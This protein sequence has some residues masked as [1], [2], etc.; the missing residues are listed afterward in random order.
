MGAE[1]SAA[2]G[3]PALTTAGAGA[4]IDPLLA[5][6]SPALHAGSRHKSRRGKTTT[7]QRQR[8]RPP[9]SP[10]TPVAALN[11]ACYSSPGCSTHMR[12]ARDKA[13]CA[14]P[15]H[16]QDDYEQGDDVHSPAGHGC[17]DGTGMSDAACVRLSFPNSPPVCPRPPPN[18]AHDDNHHHHHHHQSSTQSTVELETPGEAVAESAVPATVD[19]VSLRASLPTRPAYV[20]IAIP[21]AAAASQIEQE[22]VHQEEIGKRGGARNEGSRGPQV[23]HS[24][25]APAPS[26][27]YPTPPS[28]TIQPGKISRQ[29][30][31]ST[32]AIAT[33]RMQDDTQQ[34][35]QQ[36]Q[37]QHQNGRASDNRIHAKQKRGL[38]KPGSLDPPM[39]F[40]AATDYDKLEGKRGTI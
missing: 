2:I 40:S 22:Y 8:Q 33:Q 27:L 25:S 26:N 35:Q 6:F 5:D 28:P 4:A 20:D 34:Q 30:S 17:R 10:P 31:A 1:Q 21:S 19:P 16:P 13:P 9:P 18:Q 15:P 36:Q 23:H 14:S 29:A 38:L 7:R 32:P 3:R 37:Q 11:R 12:R 39:H 24:A